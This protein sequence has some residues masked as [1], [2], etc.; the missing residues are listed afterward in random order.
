MARGQ[1][2]QGKF[3]CFLWLLLLAAAVMVAYRMV[4]VKIRSAEFYDFIVEQAKFSARRPPDQIRRT[5][6]KRAKELDIP[7]EPKNLRVEK[8]GDRIIIDCQYVISVDLPFYTY[9]WEFHHELD[10]P[11]FWV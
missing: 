2:G 6:L 3:G 11:I 9:V 10:R 1:S 5:I 4:P 7:L 8:R